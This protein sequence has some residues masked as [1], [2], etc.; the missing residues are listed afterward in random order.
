LR[1]IKF[2]EDLW[3]SACDKLVAPGPLRCRAERADKFTTDDRI[4]IGATSPIGDSSD[5]D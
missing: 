2:R 5:G 3:D 4:R 1:E